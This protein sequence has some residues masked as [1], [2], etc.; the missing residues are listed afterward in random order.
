MDNLLVPNNPWGVSTLEFEVLNI[1]WQV[2]PPFL[3]LH[4]LQ[5]GSSEEAADE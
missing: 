1:E 4:S 3:V 2:V 5:S